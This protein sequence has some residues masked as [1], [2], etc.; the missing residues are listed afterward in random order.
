MEPS[1]DLFEPDDD[2]L[3]AA[4]LTQKAQRFDVA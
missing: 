2:A 3:S 1:F 4:V